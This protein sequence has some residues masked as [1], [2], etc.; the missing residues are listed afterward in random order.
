MSWRARI[1][2]AVRPV[3]QSWWRLSRGTTLGVRAIVT[4]NAA[5]V[6]LV[7]HTYVDGWYLPGGGVE[8]GEPAEEAMRRELAEEAGVD[9]TG[10]LQLVG[11]YN[12]HRSFPGDHV[13]LYTVGQWKPC[14]T[15]HAGEIAEVSWFALDALPAETT[16][17]TRRR[18]QEFS[19]GARPSHD[20]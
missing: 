1:E 11:I 18:L 13:V 9:A 20:W 7:R 19:S 17:A 10:N 14:A 8:R 3:I 6:A 15:D 2:P 5:R 16:P 4:D 12:N